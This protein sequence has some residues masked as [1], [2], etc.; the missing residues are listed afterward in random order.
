MRG[1]LTHLPDRIR[2]TKEPTMP[3]SP[4]QAPPGRQ[5]NRT[6]VTA[7]STQ[8]EP[9]KR[10]RG[11]PRIELGAASHRG[12]GCEGLAAEG[13]RV[14]RIQERFGDRCER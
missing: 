12:I 13:C 1:S 5:V 7:D 8:G 6:H 4:L 14:A 3:K 10:F 9:R 11:R 2:K